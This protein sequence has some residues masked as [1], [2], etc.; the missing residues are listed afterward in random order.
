MQAERH[1]LQLGTQTT[2]SVAVHVHLGVIVL[3]FVGGALQVGVGIAQEAK[4][5]AA[6]TPHSGGVAATGT[7]ALQLVVSARGAVALLLG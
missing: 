1:Q 2:R 5:H 7:H 3:E 4:Q 6:K